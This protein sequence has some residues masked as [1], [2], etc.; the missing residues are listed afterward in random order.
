MSQHRGV[1]DPLALQQMSAGASVQSRSPAR[2]GSRLGEPLLAQSYGFDVDAPDAG[3]GL[4]AGELDAD[5][6][7][8][9]VRVEL[10]DRHDAVVE[11]DAEHRLR[12]GSHVAH[13]AFTDCGGY[14]AAIG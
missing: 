5:R 9:V 7:V 13:R 11:L 12:N 1:A 8:L 6:R 3:A 14:T 4:D 10:R 2:P